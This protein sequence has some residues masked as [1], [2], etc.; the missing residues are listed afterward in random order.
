MDDFKKTLLGQPAHDFVNEAFTNWH[1]LS[2]TMRSRLK[3]GDMPVYTFLHPN[4]NPEDYYNFKTMANFNVKAHIAATTSFVKGFLSRSQTHAL[5]IDDP[6]FNKPAPLTPSKQQPDF[7]A[8]GK[9][10]YYFIPHDYKTESFDSDFSYTRRGP[11]I[12]VFLVNMPE[13]MHLRHQQEIDEAFIEMLAE[14]T[15]TV[16]TQAWDFDGF[17]FLDVN[18]K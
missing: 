4:A 2:K 14:H 15:V 9:E 1:A 12:N 7:F 17:L 16:G 18:P 3:F 5:I 10:L 6:V 8:L 13:E 11:F